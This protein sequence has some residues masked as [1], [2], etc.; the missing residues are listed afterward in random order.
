MALRDEFARSGT[1]LFRWRSYLPLLFLPVI[2]L[3]LQNF[4]YLGDSEILDDLW[5]ALCFG[6]AALGLSLRVLTVGFVPAH[7]SGRNTRR[8]E[9]DALNT[10][11]MYSIVRHPLYLGNF[12]IWMGVSLFPHTWWLMLIA[13]LAFW[14]YYERIMF[15]EEEFLR[16]QFGP[17]FERWAQR[18][19]AFI[20]A[21]RNW[22]PPA[23]SFSWRS[24]L[25][26]ENAT[27][28]AII[29]TLFLLE[30]TGDYFA[31]E[32]T[33]VDLGWMLIVSGGL[34]VYAL[35]RSMKKRH[36]LSVDGR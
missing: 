21:L 7:T 17:E 33:H 8:Q 19:P 13:I 5:E 22:R 9:A 23:L 28:F 18:T 30:V 14:V 2:V 10:T 27:L 36:W 1:Y 25:A 20:P 32:M 15:A 31:G 34:V 16:T 11:G 35:L 29:V 4:H 6:V 3:A 12:L 24:A 26:R